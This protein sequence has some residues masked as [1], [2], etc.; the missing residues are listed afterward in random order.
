VAH[1]EARCTVSILVNNPD[2]CVE[3]FTRKP[4]SISR[5]D[6]DRGGHRR[7]EPERTKTILCTFVHR[8]SVD[9]ATGGRMDTKFI[10]TADI[11]R[12]LL[13][14]MNEYTEYH[15]AVAWGSS[16]DIA[17]RLIANRTKIKRILFGTHFCQ[18]DPDLLQ[19]LQHSAW[20]R[21]VPQTG[22]GTFHPKVYC[23][24]SGEKRAVIIGSANFTNAGIGANVEAGVLLT[25]RT[26]EKC[27]DEA[28][29]F[30]ERLWR[31]WEKKG[32]ITDEFLS[33]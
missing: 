26:G 25:G 27:I 29:E 21:V 1:F 20:V 9:Q 10:E 2:F 12:E 28:F 33:A 17:E 24:T 8:Y 4:V 31:K 30:V 3:S 23:F 11:R 15:W 32:R 13:G 5:T 14:L 22:A 6:E 18:T 19:D 7:M 16:G